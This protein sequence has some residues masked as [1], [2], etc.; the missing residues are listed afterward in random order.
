MGGAGKDNTAYNV[1]IENYMSK[2]DKNLQ[3]G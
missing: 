1:L 2:I 3:T